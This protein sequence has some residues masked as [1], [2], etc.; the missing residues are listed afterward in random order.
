MKLQ[1]IRNATMRLEYAGHQLL[2][3]PYFAA[4]HSMPSFAKVSLNPTVD[5]PMPIDDILQDVEALYGLT[6]AQ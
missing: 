6:F 3:D 1:L 2:L 4:K 5:L